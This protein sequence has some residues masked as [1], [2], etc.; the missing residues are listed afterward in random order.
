MIAISLLL[1][2]FIT[3]WFML[4]HAAENGTFFG[5]TVEPP[6]R[7]KIE[8]VLRGNV[9][10]SPTRYHALERDIH[11]YL[12]R[13][14]YPYYSVM[15][16]TVAA[17]TLLDLSLGLTWIL[18]GMPSS[19]MYSEQ[20]FIEQ[21]QKAL[22]S[23]ELDHLLS[24][25]WG[26]GKI[27]SALALVDPEPH[28]VDRKDVFDHVLAQS[29][30]TSITLSPS[31]S[32]P[33]ES[34]SLTPDY[35]VSL[36]RTNQTAIFTSQVYFSNLTITLA[37]IS[38][39][40]GKEEREEFESIA[41]VFFQDFLPH[42]N[43]LVLDIQHVQ[44]LS[45]SLVPSSA[46]RLRDGQSLVFDVE[47]V[48]EGWSSDP[49]ILDILPFDS[50][51][52]EVLDKYEQH[53][54]SR[55]RASKDNVW[56]LDVTPP[57]TRDKDP[58]STPSPH[59]EGSNQSV[60]TIIMIVCVCGTLLVGVAGGAFWLLRKVDDAESVCDDDEAIQDLV[61]EESLT[62]SDISKLHPSRWNRRSHFK[63]PL[64]QSRVDSERS[65]RSPSLW[66][67]SDVDNWSVISVSFQEEENMLSRRVM[68]TCCHSRGSKRVPWLLKGN[69]ARSRPLMISKQA[70][71]STVPFGE[72]LPMHCTLLNIAP[73]NPNSPYNLYVTNDPM[74]FSIGD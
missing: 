39:T 10:V 69:F 3:T 35:D 24:D 53:F 59:T 67:D 42:M 12:N 33:T 6:W 50:I 21:I 25:E 49:M 2:N 54:Y 18:H 32:F 14:L 56:H 45:H 46:H 37:G 17:Q 31:S 72:L 70:L 16:T 38:A 40:V 13:A 29:S 5:A 66:S 68:L 34:P 62:A 64:Q 73:K 11:L 7:T 47:I 1:I 36:D 27:T 58:S 43:D 23:T 61:D 20:D 63:Y 71:Q 74:I 28:P 26:I 9:P 41:R 30:A 60:V 65:S 52:H 55:L 44:V 19:D 8:L 22:G 15:N 57:T 48:G 4:T 51:V